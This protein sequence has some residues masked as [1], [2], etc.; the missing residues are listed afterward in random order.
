MLSFLYHDWSHAEFLLWLMQFLHFL[1]CV[2][3]LC[4]IKSVFLCIAVKYVSIHCFMTYYSKINWVCSSLWFCC[5][6]VYDL[7]LKQRKLSTELL[8]DLFL[9]NVSTLWEGEFSGNAEYVLSIHRTGSCCGCQASYW[10]PLQELL[11][12]IRLRWWT[13]LTPEG[14]LSSRQWAVNKT[15][16][17]C[18][19]S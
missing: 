8:P 18:F 1:F 11:I 2:I 10:Q 3:P 16:A 15:E 7:K 14:K 19:Q 6:S 9:I 17:A 4:Q 12:K 5:H 13:L